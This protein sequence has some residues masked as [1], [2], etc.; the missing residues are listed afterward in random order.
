MTFCSYLMLLQ[1]GERTENGKKAVYKL[2]VNGTK[3]T[4]VTYV[5]Q[6]KEE[7]HNFYF[8]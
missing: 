6:N 1:N 4:V 5:K 2:D 3:Y 7:F 8:K